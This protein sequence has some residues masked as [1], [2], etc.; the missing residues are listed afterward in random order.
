[1]LT[2]PLD[3]AIGSNPWKTLAPSDITIDPLTGNYIVIAAR[4]QALI[5]I[6][7][8]GEVVR[9]RPLPGPHEQAEG[10]VITRDSILM[11]SDEAVRNPAMITLY[12]WP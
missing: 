9:S 3:D 10:V 6:T 7:P 5:E 8:S 2:I 11:I 12:R 4:Q 1:M